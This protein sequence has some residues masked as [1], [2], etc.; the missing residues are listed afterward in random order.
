MEAESLPG[1]V[2]QSMAKEDTTI[3]PFVHLIL[4]DD[5]AE[6]N[7]PTVLDEY[8]KKKQSIPLWSRS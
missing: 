1:T 5:L 4:N 8:K 3:D 6:N 2:T 7:W